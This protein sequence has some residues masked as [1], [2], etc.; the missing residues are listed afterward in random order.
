MHPFGR[1]EETSRR[2]LFGFFTRCLTRG[3]WELAA[4]CVGQL[5]DA[6]G[7][8]PHGPHNIVKAI[9]TH[10]YPLRWETV[11]SPHRLAWY[12]LQI[13][14]TQTKIKVSGSVKRELE[15]MLLL[16][17]LGDVPLSVL[18]ELHEAFLYSQEVKGNIP[19]DCTTPLSAAVLSCLRSLL[20]RQQ[21]QLCHS[22]ISF[23]Q[24][25]GHSRDHTLQDV[26]I[27]HLT[28]RVNVP[29]EERNE[30]WV[31]EVCSALALAPWGPERSNAQLETLWK[32][33]WSAREG[34]MTE[35]RILGCLLRP[36]GQGQG[37]GQAQALLTSYSSTAL[38]LLKEKLLRE[39]PQTQE[40]C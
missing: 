5:G 29:V 32:G 10:P 31:E 30:K 39:A 22:L 36:Q 14:E 18:K 34:P 26:F 9:V 3:E 25:S 20:I 21:P 28:E 6:S 37:Q 27:Q 8:D 11:G 38:R 33:L 12:W 1:E 40:K 2:E 23:L 4:A 15:F 7:D 24:H 17:E 19:G 16:E 35:E 13:L